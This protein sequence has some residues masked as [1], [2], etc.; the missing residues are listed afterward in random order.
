[1]YL[2]VPGWGLGS[3]ARIVIPY[4]SDCTHPVTSCERNQYR[5]NQKE[6]WPNLTFGRKVQP[7]SERRF[8]DIVVIR[9]TVQVQ[10]AF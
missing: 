1:M 8:P 9:E 7:A 6:A 3:P 2:E 4:H 10:E 5:I